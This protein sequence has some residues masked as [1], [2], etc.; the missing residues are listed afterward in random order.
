[1]CGI[2]GPVHKVR[3]NIDRIGTSPSS[4]SWYIACVFLKDTNESNTCGL[5]ME[6][7]LLF[8]QSR[9]E[10]ELDMPGFVVTVSSRCICIL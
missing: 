2:T 3:S 1:M 10:N 9:I 8:P 6:I 4:N 7:G 5:D